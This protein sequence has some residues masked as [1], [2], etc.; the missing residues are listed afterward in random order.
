MNSA[1]NSMNM[2]N[3]YHILKSLFSQKIQENKEIG[4]HP[5]TNVGIF[6]AKNINEGMTISGVYIS[7]I[8]TCAC[9]EFVVVKKD[10][11]YKNIPSQDTIFA[12]GQKI[13]INNKE[14]KVESLINNRN[15]YKVLLPSTEA[16]HFL[17]DKKDYMYIN[18][19]QIICENEYKNNDD[20][21]F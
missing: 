5:D 12:P 11:F 15:I 17:S 8:I 7:G 20:I 6:K 1:K 19:I 18:N 10:T 3:Q 2:I 14:K 13:R 21:I 9:S 4:I 16:I